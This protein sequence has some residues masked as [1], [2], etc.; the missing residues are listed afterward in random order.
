MMSFRFDARSALADI[1][2]KSNDRPIAATVPTPLQTPQRSVGR[3]GT[4][5]EA[6]GKNTTPSLASALPGP[7]NW[8]AGDWWVFFDERADIAEYDGG[9]SRQDAETRAFDCCISEW[10]MRNPVGSTPDRC[11]H[12]DA[13]KWPGAELKPFGYPPQG[14][15]WLHAECWRDWYAGQRKDAMAFLTAIGIS[16]GS[17]DR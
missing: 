14:P 7:T 5:D 17:T 15:T 1:K 8:E 4:I 10:L 3:I 6:A 16:N 11:A 12:C 9:L 13:P 2:S